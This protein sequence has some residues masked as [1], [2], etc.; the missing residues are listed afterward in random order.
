M[1]KIHSVLTFWRENTTS[2]VN[3]CQSCTCFQ[4]LSVLNE[5]TLILPDKMSDSDEYVILIRKVHHV[6]VDISKVNLTQ[7]QDEN[8]E[9]NVTHISET[10][11]SPDS[12]TSSKYFFFILIKL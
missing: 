8:E 10:E 9:D 5:N 1:S 11:M 7:L 12:D 2:C 4:K 3:S 6:K